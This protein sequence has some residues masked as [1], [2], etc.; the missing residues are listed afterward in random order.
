[1]CVLR[2][3][4]RL[5]WRRVGSGTSQE[6]T[7][8]HPTHWSGALLGGEVGCVLAGHERGTGVH[9][10]CHGLAVDHLQ[11]RVDAQLA[12]LGRELGDGRIL[13][14]GVICATSA[15]KASKPTRMTS[16]GLTLAFV[17]DLTAPNIGGPQ[18][19]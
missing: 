15:G 19:P 11:Q 8:D 5:G 17:S 7:A 10:W 1:M 3:E 9:E 14:A 4:R 13:C 2:M 12:D 6:R 16:S 18:A